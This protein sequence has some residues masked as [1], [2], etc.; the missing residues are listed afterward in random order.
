MIALFLLL[1]A[2]S[3]PAVAP[4][5]TQ[6]SCV[7]APGSEI[8]VCGP[9]PQAQPQPQPQQGA[10]RIPKLWPKAYGPALPSAQVNLGQGVRAQLRGQSSNSGRGRRNRSTATLSVPF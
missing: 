5:P 3:A 7:R 1:S 2:G 8:T 4:Q 10:Y 9:E 6:Q